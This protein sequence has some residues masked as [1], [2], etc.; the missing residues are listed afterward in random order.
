MH[1]DLSR[2]FE[3]FE[4]QVRDIAA[5]RVAPVVTRGEIRAELE[6]RYRF[7]APMPLAEAAADIAGVLAR[8][9]LHSVSPRYFGLFNPG[10][11]FS[12]VV[13]DLL[14]AAINPQVGGWFHGPA[15]VEIEE[16]ILA[17][18]LRAFGMPD[19]AAHFTSGG[20]EANLTA[21][22]TALACQFPEIAKGG[23]RALAKQPV[24]FVSAEAHHSFS[25][26]AQHCGIGRDAVRVVPCDERFRMRVDA[27]EEALRETRERGEE[28]FLVVATMGTTAGGAVDPIGAIADVC[29]RENLWLHADA[30]WGGAAIVSP[31]LRGALAGIERA[32]SITCDAH[33]W[34]SV[35]MGAG[36]FFTRH[37]GALPR[38]FEVDASYVPR[39]AEL[40]LYRS[41]L[42]WSRR[43]IGLKL[44]LAFAEQGVDGIA[45]QLERQQALADRLRDAL[46]QRG[47]EIVNDSPFPLVCFRREGV[48]S[49]AVVKRVVD[50]GKHWISHAVLGGTQAVIRACITNHE[51][52]ETD[53]D[54]LVEAL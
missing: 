20:S 7:D 12:S 25:K 41:S 14:T 34:F 19:G 8:G 44:F 2:L 18:L 39:G 30:A 33:K 54:A 13:A 28:P 40:D 43:L 24:F 32:D 47:W 16:T 50:E 45:A 49:A 51:T 6:A 42:Q 17:V 11:R 36:M 48:D 46:R 31:K 23:V 29:Q 53:V 1:F 10:A 38:A 5:R 27:L 15:A 37:P 26:I 35:A 9:G 3:E 4:A 22:L 21:V 52:T